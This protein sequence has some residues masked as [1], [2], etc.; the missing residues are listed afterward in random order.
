MLLFV[1]GTSYNVAVNKPISENKKPSIIRR[2][3]NWFTDWAQKPQAEGALFGFTF[4]EAIIF[5]I[6]PDPLLMAMVFNK[7]K[8]WIRY[9]TITVIA[10]LVG[11]V[12]GYLFGWGLFASV[13]SWIID[14][15]HL[16]EQ[17]EAL[18]QSFQDNGFLAVL[19]AAMTPIPYKIITISA[20]AFKVNFFSFFI[21]SIIGRG[22]RF[23]GVAYLAKFLG[24]KYKN[25]IEKYIDAISIVLVVL[26]IGVIVLIS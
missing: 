1:P 20:G 19:A 24:V 12:V 26:A 14:T 2:F 11:G 4:I 15:Y 22:L 13:G 21:A 8:R 3:Y 9:A 23:F 25:Q 7:P 6:P 10:T 5:P 16:Q 18:G 17:Y